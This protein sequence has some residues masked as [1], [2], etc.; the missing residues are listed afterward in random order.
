MSGTKNKTVICHITTIHPAYDDR[1][2]YKQCVS[3]VKKGFEVHLVARNNKDECKK[4]VIIHGI[5]HYSSRIKRF[6]LGS[7]NAFFLSLKIKADVYQFHDPELILLGLVLKL[8]GKKVIFDFHELVVFQIESKYYVKSNFIKKIA[9]KVYLINEK[10]AVKY[11]DAILLAEDGYVQYFEKKYQKYITRFFVVRNYSMVDFIR[12]FDKPVKRNHSNIIYVGGLSVHRGIKET[13][14]A[15]EILN[16]P[17]RFIIL[18]NWET[19]SY[20]EECKRLEGWK[21][22]DYRGFKLLDELYKDMNE[23]DIGVALLHPIRNYTISLPVKIFEYMSL[24]KP[25][26]MS[27]FPLWKKTFNDI[28]YFADPLDPYAI[29]EELKVILSTPEEAMK[30]GKKGMEIVA[31]KYNWENEM[32]N[33]LAA[34]QYAI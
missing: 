21:Y 8:L 6:I 16:L 1:I 17:I 33:Y 13:I 34:I 3:L 20:F 2:F 30:K 14:Q 24:G 11:F 26:L 19:E 9:L 22:V 31:K 18:G 28:G 12:G 7:M 23:A 27:D 4:G 25:V 10:L 15:L 5:S 32:K 29:A